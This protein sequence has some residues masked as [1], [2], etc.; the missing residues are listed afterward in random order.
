MPASPGARAIAYAL[1]AVVIQVV[2]VTAYAWPAARLAPRH[3]PVVVAGPAGPA[4]AVAAQ[5]Q[6]QRPAAFDV[7]WV[8]SQAAARQAIT[9]RRAYGAIVV[10]GQAPQVLTASAASPAVAQMLTQIAGQMAGRVPRSAM[11]CR[12]PRMTRTVPRSPRCCWHW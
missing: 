8:P 1:I 10:G 6:H 9:G 12:P 4:D 11:S 7:T 3:L 5:I 2:M